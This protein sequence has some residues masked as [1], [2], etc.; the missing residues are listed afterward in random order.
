MSVKLCW[1]ATR[2]AFIGVALVRF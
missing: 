2:A 1:L